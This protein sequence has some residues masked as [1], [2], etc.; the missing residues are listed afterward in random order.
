[1]LEE[2][3]LTLEDERQ[4]MPAARCRRCGVVTW[5]CSLLNGLTKLENP[6]HHIG[7]HTPPSRLDLKLMVEALPRGLRVAWLQRLDRTLPDDEV[8]A[9]ADGL[10]TL[11]GETLCDT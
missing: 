11:L 7:C 10:L 5:K 3:Q 9:L 6:R 2:I 4:V 8:H 1:M